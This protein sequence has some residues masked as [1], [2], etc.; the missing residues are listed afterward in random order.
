MQ[1]KI[2]YSINKICIASIFFMTTSY[3]APFSKENFIPIAHRISW[4]ITPSLVQ[5]I[6]SEGIQHYIQRQLHPNLNVS[7]HEE[8]QQQISNLTISQPAFIALIVQLEQNRKEADAIP[9]ADAKKIAKKNY[10]DQLKKLGKEAET[11]FLL[12]ALYSPY[13][14]QEQM[15]W[16]WMNH[17]NINM[18]KNNLEAMIGDYEEHAIR[19]YVLGKFSDLLKA[20]IKHPAM[21]SYLDNQKNGKNHI[22]ENYARELMELHTLGVEGGYNQNDV[23]ELARILTGLS[24]NLTSN[25]PQYRAELQPQYQFIREGLFEFNPKR[26][27]FGNKNFLGTTI[28]GRGLDEVNDVIDILSKSPATAHFISQK[29]AI[30]FVSDNPSTLLIEK[31]A[32]TFL[33]SNG[34]IAAVLQTMFS[35]KE[36][37]QSLGKKF[38][39]PLHYVISSIRL[40]YDNK[41]I[42]NTNPIKHWLNRMGEPLYSHPTPD[43]YSMLESAWSGSGQMTARFEIAKA[44]G[45][46]NAGLFK[47]EGEQNVEKAAFPQLMN[48]LYYEF[49]Q[50]KLSAST[51]TILDQ[52]TSPQEWNLLFLSAPEAMF[53]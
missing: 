18:H 42:L 10:K 6:R 36:F 38:K 9:D 37:S 29:L 21:L 17:F 43:G 47:I 45:K 22:N 12:R 30:F 25:T 40:A 53:R 46:G 50:K 26:H 52:S 28:Q 39:D 4:G 2:M 41:V 44:I 49:L 5:E 31:M 51:L 3:S 48:A 14:L 15:V 7:L 23:Q 32:Q 19:P 27:D 16:F 35:S 11:R 20:T 34:D 24:V 33:N 13:Q 1:K 8:A